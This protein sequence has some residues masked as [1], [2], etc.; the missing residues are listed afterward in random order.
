MLSVEEEY[1]RVWGEAGGAGRLQ[2]AFSLY[3]EMRAMLEYQVRKRHP[4]LSDREVMIKVARRMYL[5]DTAAQR[6]LDQMENDSCSTSTSKHVLNESA[7]STM[8]E[9]PF[10]IP[11]ESITT[12]W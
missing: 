4:E 10:V 3:A 12:G 8:G 7:P 11:G 1:F 6:L 2:R 5:S 9:K